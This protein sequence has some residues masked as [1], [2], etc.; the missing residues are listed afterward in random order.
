MPQDG[1]DLVKIAARVAGAQ[2]VPWTKGD[3]QSDSALGGWFFV[4]TGKDVSFKQ[5][6]EAKSWDDLVKAGVPMSVVSELQKEKVFGPADASLWLGDVYGIP[7]TK[8]PEGPEEGKLP[9]EDLPPLFKKPGKI[10][11]S[12]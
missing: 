6:D 4:D 11:S 2:A 3:W 7:E 1:M 9:S 8:A 12:S 10:L 5:L